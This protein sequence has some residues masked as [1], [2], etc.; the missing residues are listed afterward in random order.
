[1]KMSTS[2]RSIVLISALAL[3]NGCATSRSE[4]KLSSPIST[5]SVAVASNGKTAV[6]RFV[7][8]ERV[9]EQAP[10][11]ASTPS[12]GF[13]G[14]DQATAE[15]KMRAIGRKRNGYGKALGD[16]LLQS[17]QTVE[18]VIRENLSAA[19][20]Q[21]GYQVKNENTA[22][23]SPL[24]IDVH[25]KQFWAWFQPGFWALTLK[26]NIGT[27]LAISGA[28]SPISI[29]THSEFNRQVATESAWMDIVNKALEDYRAEVVAKAKSFP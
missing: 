19:L 10:K 15:T 22:G 23:Q 5:P 9:F 26:A 21:A 3:L 16:I 20:V 6:I 29:N 11:D 7:K 1:M 18:S 25:I 8:D 27:D 12:L 2:L 4:I 14:A 13:E 28:Q 17:G 24:V